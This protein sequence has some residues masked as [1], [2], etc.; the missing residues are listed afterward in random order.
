MDFQFNLDSYPTIKEQQKAARPGG[1]ASEAP[2]SS[3]MEFTK[4]VADERGRR[5]VWK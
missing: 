3:S 1:Q 5:K 2:L 4:I